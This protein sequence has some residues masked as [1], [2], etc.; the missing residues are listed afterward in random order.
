MIMVVMNPTTVR[1][2]R[3]PL[4]EGEDDILQGFSGFPAKL[5]SRKS[6]KYEE[7]QVQF[8][9][10]FLALFV[11]EHKTEKRPRP[12]G[13]RK[14]SVCNFSFIIGGLRFIFLSLATPDTYNYRFANSCPCS[15]HKFLSFQCISRDERSCQ[16]NIKLNVST[17]AKREK[18]RAF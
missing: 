14:R 15:I 11:A 16:C 13:R 10:C 4:E 17:V 5:C 1:G 18:F 7:Q 3:V 2:V 9:A 8:V 12:E 6:A